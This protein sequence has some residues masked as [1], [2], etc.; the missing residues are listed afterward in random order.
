[1][2]PR[3]Y[4][5]LLAAV[6]LT[7]GDVGRLGRYF[8]RRLGAHVNDVDDCEA[9]FV[10]GVVRALRRLDAARHGAR[11]YLTL[12]GLGTMRR[13][14]RGERR[15]AMARSLDAPTSAEGDGTLGE[16]LEETRP[17][18]ACAG[19]DAADLRRFLEYAMAACLTARE[20]AVLRALV[21]GRGSPRACAAG[22]GVSGQRLYQIRDTALRRLRRRLKRFSPAVAELA[23]GGP[24]RGPVALRDA[25][26]TLLPLSYARRSQEAPTA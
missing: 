14:L 24:Q 19:L 5:E 17:L 6:G 3:P 1:M 20:A 22:W 13:Y 15:H 9:E 2:P 25:R 18:A 21:M 16:A 12:S 4:D 11:S 10:A 23:D 8:A 26:A 7:W